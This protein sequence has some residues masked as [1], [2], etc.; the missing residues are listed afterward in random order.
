M[1]D[2]YRTFT[3]PSDPEHGAFLRGLAAQR[4]LVL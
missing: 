2:P 1:S 3:M 4:R